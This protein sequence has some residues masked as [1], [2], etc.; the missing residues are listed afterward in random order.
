MLRGGDSLQVSPSSRLF[1]INPGVSIQPCP[2]SLQATARSISTATM[3][4]TPCSCIV[5]PI[6]CSAISMAILLWLMN[7]NCVLPDMLLTRR[8]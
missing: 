8:A 6:S 7:K 2:G 1:Q 4:E 5:T 3:R